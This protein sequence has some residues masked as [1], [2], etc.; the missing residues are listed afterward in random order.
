MNKNKLK[1]IIKEEIQKLNEGSIPPNAR[2]KIETAMNRAKN[3]NGIGEQLARIGYKA[4]FLRDP[5]PHYAF[6]IPGFPEK[7]AIVNK[8]DTVPTSE[9][10]VTRLFVCGKI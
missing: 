1:E 7:Y 4:V 10:I 6:K 2:I 9:D 3:L 5:I 8:E